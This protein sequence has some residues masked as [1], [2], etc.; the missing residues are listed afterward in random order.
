MRQKCVNY[1]IFLF[2]I[3]FDNFW[4]LSIIE[5]VRQF[6][7]FS[8]ILDQ[9]HFKK[10]DNL[11]RK[12]GKL[13]DLLFRSFLIIFKSCIALNNLISTWPIFT[14]LSLQA[15]TKGRS[16]SFYTPIRNQEIEF[17]QIGHESSKKIFQKNL[18]D[19]LG[20]LD[21]YWMYYGSKW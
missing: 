19:T 3:D 10:N 17:Y 16:R 18:A 11:R 12:S 14:L 13:H 4:L 5:H 15:G 2:L 20:I 1:S 9:F 8:T 7:T 6:W 21:A